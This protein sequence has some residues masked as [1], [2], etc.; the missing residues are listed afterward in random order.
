MSPEEIKKKIE[1]Y[2]KE[3]ERVWDTKFDSPEEKGRLIDFLAKR[4]LN[5]SYKQSD[6]E[7][8]SHVRRNPHLLVQL[9]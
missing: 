4:R 9:S 6:L 3:I 7:I 5:L 2:E 8:M 1:F